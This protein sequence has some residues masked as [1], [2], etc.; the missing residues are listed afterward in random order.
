VN[1]A[2]LGALSAATDIVSIESL[3]KTIPE[4]VPRNPTANVEACQT[5]HARMRKEVLVVEC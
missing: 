2:I 4:F 5:A 3:E 1:T